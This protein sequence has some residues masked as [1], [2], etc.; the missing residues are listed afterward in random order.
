M[1]EGR[2]SLVESGCLRKVLPKADDKSSSNHHVVNRFTRRLLIATAIWGGCELPIEL[3]LSED[4][5]KG[6]ACLLGRGI[7]CGVVCGVLRSGRV[8]RVAFV[9]LCGISVVTISL[10]LPDEFRMFPIGFVFSA[11]ECVLKGA[12]LVAFMSGYSSRRNS[13]L[14]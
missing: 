7:W 8:S 3:W 14:I 9:F 12:S 11:V 13:H 10:G 4:V 1:N 6:V 2:R 5:W